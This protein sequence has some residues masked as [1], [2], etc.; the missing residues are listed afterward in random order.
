MKKN[1][2]GQIISYG[3]GNLHA[4]VVIEFLVCMYE[5]QW[6]SNSYLQ[7]DVWPSGVAHWLLSD[8]VRQLHYIMGPIHIFRFTKLHYYRYNNTFCR[9]S[10]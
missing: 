10:C 1:S 3:F 9:K 7:P 6:Y 4:D 2:V 5:S 8:F